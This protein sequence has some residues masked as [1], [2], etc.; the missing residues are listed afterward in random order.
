MSGALG[1]GKLYA[2]C[3]LDNTVRKAVD[4]DKVMG[5]ARMRRDDNQCI[6]KELDGITFSI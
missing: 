6:G 3:R 1:L 5:G 4:P 2:G